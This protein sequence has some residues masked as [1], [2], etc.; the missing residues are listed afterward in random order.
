VCDSQLLDFIFLTSH[1][2]KWVVNYLWNQEETHSL[3]QRF[4]RVIDQVV[5][6]FDSVFHVF[7]MLLAYAWISEDMLE[8]V[9]L[10]WEKS[11]FLLGS[12][13]QRTLGL[14]TLVS[15]SGVGTEIDYDWLWLLVRIL[16]A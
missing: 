10:V 3:K 5:S 12:Y 9:F 4:L 16:Y 8:F 13:S 2:K 6:L 7:Y 11:R 1:G 15:F 14:G